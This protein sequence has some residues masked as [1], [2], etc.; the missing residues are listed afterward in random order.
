MSIREL[1]ETCR[2]SMT[3]I[4]QFCRS[5]DRLIAEAHLENMEGFR[6]RL[7]AHPPRGAT[8]E[9][10]VRGVMRSF[11]KA[12][13]VDE[14]L[15]RTLMRA[16]YSLDPEVGEARMSVGNAYRTMID[17]A[18]GDDELADRDAVIGTLGHVI[19]DAIL[20]WLIGRHDADWVHGELDAT[21]RT[22]MRA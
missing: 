2:M 18:I 22:L 4:Y 6:R 15:T 11:V 14:V 16:M 8:A 12:L 21:V 9:E 3:T 19:D 20:N 1:A 7:A 5:K 10:R 13:V 17:A